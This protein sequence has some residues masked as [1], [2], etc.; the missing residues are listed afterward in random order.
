MPQNFYNQSIKD[1][2]KELS[3][4][5]EN[6]L[7]SE[8]VKQLQEKYGPNSLAGKKKTSMLQRFIAQFK[9]FMII[10]LII[11]ALLS[12][13]VAQEWTDAAIIMMVNTIA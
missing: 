1:I 12:G 3:T 10:V 2:E 4:S 9:D 7:N 11:A 5:C 13:F 8:Q 6:G